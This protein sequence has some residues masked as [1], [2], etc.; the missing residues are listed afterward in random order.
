MR[1]RR[2]PWYPALL[3]GLATTLTLSSADLARAQAPAGA[4]T[5]PVSRG[6]YPTGPGWSGYAPP[7]GWSGYAP[8]TGWTGYAP[9]TTAVA[10]P[11]LPVVPGTGPRL[12]TNPPA[13]VPAPV[14][15]PGV[16]AGTGSTRPDTVVTRS[17]VVRRRVS[18]YYGWQ[19]GP[20]SAAYREFGSGRNVPLA[21]PWLPGSP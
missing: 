6:T 9:G 10:P 2:R 18:P 11:A 12:A 8:Q 1:S 15:Q 17:G 19:G 13:S 21:K 4:M 14:Y 16:V 3:F 20:N 7:A 5:P